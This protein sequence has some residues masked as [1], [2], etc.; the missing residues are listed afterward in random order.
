MSHQGLIAR[1]LTLPEQRLGAWG[2]FALAAL[3]YALGVVV[4]LLW[5]P[6][7]TAVDGTTFGGSPTLTVTDG[8]FFAA[9]V[10]DALEGLHGASLRVPDWGDHAITTL[11]V[12][13]TWLTGAAPMDVMFYLPAFV[14]P[15]LAVPLVL[16]GRLLGNDWWGFAAACMAVVGVS[17]FNRTLPGYFDT[18]MF[19]VT[20]PTTLVGPPP[21]AVGGRRL[22]WP[23]AA[24]A[25][26]VV[27]P[28]FYNQIDA[29]LVAL[30][31]G[32][33]AYV[34]AFHR[35][36]RVAWLGVLAVTVALWDAPGLLR[37]ALIAALPL[38]ARHQR[39]TVP[40]VAAA[41]AV[42]FIAFLL[43]SPGVAL[44]LEQ[45]GRFAAR[46]DA[47]AAAP[48][49]V[50]FVQ[51][52]AFIR[53]AAVLPFDQMA[54]RFAGSV[55]AMWLAL[56][57]FAL[58][59]LR[60]RP[61]LLALPLVALGAFSL[62]GGLRFTI[63]GVP[64]A[65]LGATWVAVLVAG[66]VDRLRVPER[67]AP[68]KGKRRGRRTPSP[69][70]ERPPWRP[71]L[72]VVTSTL[73]ITALLVTPNVE[74]SLARHPMTV[75]HAGEAEL[76]GHLA[77]ARAPG[78]YAIAWWDYG[79]PLW[80]FGQV[81]TLL[82]GGR[83]G[84]DH[85]LVSLALFTDSPLQAVN[86]ARTAVE[87]YHAAGRGYRFVTDALFREARE[88]SQTPRDLLASMAAA[89]YM[90]PP[91]TRDVYLYLPHRQLNLM[92]AIERF[93]GDARRAAD[94]PARRPFGLFSPGLQRQGDVIGFADGVAFD[95]ASGLL[96]LRADGGQVH[97]RPAAALWQV[98]LMQDGSIRS[99]LTRR[100]ADVG[101][102]VVLLESYG[103]ALVLDQALFDSF[104]VQTY[105]FDRYDP[106]LLEP[107]ARTPWG[108]V[109]KLL[110]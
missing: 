31:L 76:M 77:E 45:V 88:A 48:G 108:A 104:Y 99:R 42:A 28:F 110:R 56:I 11:A 2:A 23:L 60:H 20:G 70:E 53:E 100:Y 69:P 19:A 37:L 52:S 84:P 94:A 14:A 63:F 49:D 82:D 46:G 86:L 65:A 30:G 54:H 67:A 12:A 22:P 71:G 83:H 87:R 15:L 89:D 81:N 101:A 24:A 27:A 8:Y 68:A 21:A 66:A 3:A 4:R 61:L 41:A 17:Y 78:D 40:H 98:A 72:G 7:L 57:G 34:L 29:I 43:S 10:Q 96:S 80:Y 74:G 90:P 38:A 32:F 97:Q 62:W 105:V 13:V 103:A 64:M 33:V 109:F 36:D 93:S 85:M 51:T 91:A 92:L 50:A 6:A 55:P 58:A 9:A 5:A 59:A 79:Y 35:R 25:L 107:V 73:F 102:H 39:L 106:S 16:L 75:V 1:A 26:M 44:I 95:Q 47:G 18:D